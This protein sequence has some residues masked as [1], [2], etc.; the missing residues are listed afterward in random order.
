MF[1][2]FALIDNFV[3]LRLIFLTIAGV[4]HRSTC[5]KMSPWLAEHLKILYRPEN[6]TFGL[7][8]PILPV[9]L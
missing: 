6:F 2:E 4:P 8:A 3:Y 5:S 7:T 9:R 1:H